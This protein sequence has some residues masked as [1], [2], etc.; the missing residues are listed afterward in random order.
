MISGSLSRGR[1]GG[2]LGGRLLPYAAVTFFALNAHL[3]DAVAWS[4]LHGYLLCYLCLFLSLLLGVKGV[5]RL[6][7]GKG[8]PWGL[9]LASWLLAARST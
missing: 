7:R 2:H 6:N 5:G 3:V 4:H 1:A 9:I 8:P